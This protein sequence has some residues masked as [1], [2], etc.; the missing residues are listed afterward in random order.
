MI[1]IATIR[2]LIGSY[3]EIYSLV[4]RVSDDLKKSAKNN[5]S[6]RVLTSFIEFCSILATY[7]REC[8]KSAR[9]I[10]LK[11][12]SF[13]AH[14]SAL[15]AEA[16]GN[17]GRNLNS[18]IG[19]FGTRFLTLQPEE[20]DSPWD[21]ER[22]RSSSGCWESRLSWNYPSL[23]HWFGHSGAPDLSYPQPE[24]YFIDERVMVS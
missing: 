18:S 24:V 9:H 13:L 23:L 22:R 17:R 14:I 21:W 1:N 4:R 2:C 15:G 5:H 12:A 19:R 7:I 8:Q 10:R 16:F 20:L 3:S 11:Q 6:S